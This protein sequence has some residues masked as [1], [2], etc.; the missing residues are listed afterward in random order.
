[1]LDFTHAKDKL[2]LSTIDAKSGTATNDAFSYIGSAAFSGT[3]GQLRAE[4]VGGNTVVQGDVNGD[5]VADFEIALIGFTGTISA[6]DFI[7]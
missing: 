6:S 2:D 1:M 7:L 3:A 5:G 4:H